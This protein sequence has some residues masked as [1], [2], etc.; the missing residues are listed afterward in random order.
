MPKIDA[1][2]ETPSGLMPFQQ[3]WAQGEFLSSL[4]TETALSA[5]G[6]LKANAEAAASRASFQNWQKLSI[7]SLKDQGEAFGFVDTLLPELDTFM[8]AMD[9][10]FGVPDNLGVSATQIV[11]DAI[12]SFIPDIIEGFTNAIGSIPIVGWIVKLAMSFGKLII[13]LA[14]GDQTSP[15][16]PVCFK[17]LEYQKAED[18]SLAR[19]VLQQA[20]TGDWSPIF[21]PI[22]SFADNFQGAAFACLKLTDEE[23]NTRGERVEFAPAVTRPSTGDAYFVPGASFRANAF[24]YLPGPCRQ[25]AAFQG[26]GPQISSWDSIDTYYPS[27][28]QFAGQL[29]SSMNKNTPNAFR[30]LPSPLE[31]Q[32]KEWF[33][34]CFRAGAL[35]PN[36]AFPGGKVECLLPGYGMSLGHCYLIGDLSCSITMR[37]RNGAWELFA[38]DNVHDMRKALEAA[39]AGRAPHRSGELVDDTNRADFLAFLERE[40]VDDEKNVLWRELDED[41]AFH[42]PSSAQ[43]DLGPHL[44]VS[45]WYWI[46]FVMGIYRRNC[47]RFAGTTTCAYV[48]DTFGGIWDTDVAQRWT[49]ARRELLKRPDLIEGLDLEVVPDAS[50]RT[51]LEQALKSSATS[52]QNPNLPPGQVVPGEGEAEGEVPPGMPGVDDEDVIG[53]SGGGGAGALLLLGGGLAAALALAR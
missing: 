11:G 14:Q 2:Y 53:G 16:P 4:P 28:R 31:A 39:Q 5:E 46:K 7:R 18:E 19:A 30:L 15:P 47:W 50:Y 26:G 20:A 37:Q 43:L 45:L 29:W 51:E 27:A 13:A 9:Q 17:R 21:S 52:L 33:S 48:D 24:A 10:A 6:F 25:F 40:L 35:T 12:S 38:Y 36:I 42:L 49:D 8:G 23:G 22:G 34:A 32:W 41:D 3:R 44:R 1:L